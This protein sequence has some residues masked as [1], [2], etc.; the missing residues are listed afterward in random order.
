MQERCFSSGGKHTWFDFSLL[1]YW[2]S[3]YFLT[4]FQLVSAL[5]GVRP[6][7]KRGIRPPSGGSPIKDGLH[8]GL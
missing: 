8:Y 4:K 5:G 3:D 6:P 1:I 2:L 7:P